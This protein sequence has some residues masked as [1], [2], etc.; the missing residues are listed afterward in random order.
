MEK[1]YTNNMK[2]LALLGAISEAVTNGSEDVDVTTLIDICIDY[3][4]AIDTIISDLM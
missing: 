4:K 1:I 3:S 2:V